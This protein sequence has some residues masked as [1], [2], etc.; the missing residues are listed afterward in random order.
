MLIATLM[1]IDKLPQGLYG[2]TGHVIN[3]PQECH[4]AFDL[5]VIVVRN[6]SANFLVL[7]KKPTNWKC[8]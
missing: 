7:V 2:C 3:L 4:L 6:D 5:N 1:P 8:Y